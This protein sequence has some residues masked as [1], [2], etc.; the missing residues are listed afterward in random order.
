MSNW[1][2]LS[3]KD[4]AALIQMMSQEGISSLDEMEEY[5]NAVT[6][7]TS[8]DEGGSDYS[9]EGDYQEESPQEGYS[10]SSLAANGSSSQYYI[11]ADGS[12]GVKQL[13]TYAFGGDTLSD[14]SKK[15][16]IDR[17]NQS[18]A[19]WIQRLQDRYRK[20]INNSD[21]SI[22]THKLGY[23]E[24]G[25]TAVV[26]PE[27]SGT[28]GLLYYPINPVETAIQNRDT[29]EMSIPEAE[30]FTKNY[31]DYYDGFD[32]SSGG[33]IRIKP[34]IFNGKVY[35]RNGGI[36]EGD[37]DVDDISDEELYELDRLGYDVDIL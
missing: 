10:S 20:V 34:E 15:N 37:F 13:N 24:D 23:V 28:Q 12:I 22:S 33:K 1:S 32:F 3:T 11:K 30:W 18:S 36:L 7:Q 16:L 9:G 21:G 14:K 4:R 8:P 35:Y 6:Q 19:N 2:E 5:Y 31:K 26:F 27:I 25:N 17:V 29:V